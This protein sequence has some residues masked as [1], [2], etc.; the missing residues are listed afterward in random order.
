MPRP[1]RAP[2]ANRHWLN[3]ASRRRLRETLQSVIARRCDVN[4]KIIT[5][6]RERRKLQADDPENDYIHYLEYRIERYSRRL[7]HLDLASQLFQIILEENRVAGL[8]R[9][10]RSWGRSFAQHIHTRLDEEQSETGSS[11]AASSL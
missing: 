1:S 2:R 9:R 8:L 10:T 3:H 4:W 11:S 5:A 7:R 6:S